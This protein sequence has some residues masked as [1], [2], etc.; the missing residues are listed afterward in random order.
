MAST[1]LPRAAL[2]AVRARGAAPQRALRVAAGAQDDARRSR[3]DDGRNKFSQERARDS[4]RRR[5]RP[6]YLRSPDDSP[7]YAAA[8]RPARRAP[9]LL[10]PHS[11]SLSRAQDAH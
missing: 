1:L 5:G 3:K 7:M 4:K 8:R 9:R 2:A 6:A 11:F 10:L